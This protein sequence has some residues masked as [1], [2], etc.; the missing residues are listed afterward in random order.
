[1]VARQSAGEA[2]TQPAWRNSPPSSLSHR[3]AHIL[4]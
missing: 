3:L 2:A 4:L 1:M